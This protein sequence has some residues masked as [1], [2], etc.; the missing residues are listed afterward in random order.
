MQWWVNKN[1]SRW[2]SGWR[3]CVCMCVC[4]YWRNLEIYVCPVDE[5]KGVACERKLVCE[6]V[7][8][9]FVH[10]DSW[11]LGQTEPP[12][13]QSTPDTHTLD[14][15]FKMCHLISS[16][17]LPL[18]QLPFPSL[19]FSCSIQL[20][21]PSRSHPPVE[22]KPFL[23]LFFLLFCL[24]NSV[25][26]WVRGVLTWKQDRGCFCVGKPREGQWE[27]EDRELAGWG[28]GRVEWRLCA[29]SRNKCWNP[30][31][32]LLL[33]ST[34]EEKRPRGG[35]NER[36]EGILVFVWLIWIKSPLLCVGWKV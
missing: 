35:K 2:K 4:A 16:F 20:F 27:S 17:S 10:R 14:I 32:M 25:G 23:C 31:Q 36:R 6:R 34:P 15:N 33:M 30:G 18:Y 21:P 26:G 8:G 11:P 28:W 24:I 3:L 22:Q 1:R 9:V 19:F 7:N 29:G 13:H 12:T 5:H